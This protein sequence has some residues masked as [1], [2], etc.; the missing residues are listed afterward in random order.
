MFLCSYFSSTGIRRRATP[1]NAGVCLGHAALVVDEWMNVN[2]WWNDN[3]RGKSKYKIE[4][5]IPTPYCLW[6]G[7]ESNPGPHS[8]NLATKCLCQRMRSHTR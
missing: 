3:D 8:E 7:F 2:Q 1:K 5:L 4:K 6:T